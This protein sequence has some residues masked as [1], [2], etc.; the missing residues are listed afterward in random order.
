[1]NGYQSAAPMNEHKIPMH[2]RF[3]HK[4]E[5]LV[6]GVEYFPPLI[7]DPFGWDHVLT[8][9]LQRSAHPKATSQ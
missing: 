3:Q 1:M 9:D 6:V 5:K 8:S 7:K 2:Q 4:G